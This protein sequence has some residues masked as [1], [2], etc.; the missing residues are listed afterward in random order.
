MTAADVAPPAGETGPDGHVV[1][2]RR[3]AALVRA[4][5]DTNDPTITRHP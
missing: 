5:L 1:R 3:W 4:T 2:V